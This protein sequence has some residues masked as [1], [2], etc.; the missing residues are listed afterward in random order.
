M[1]ESSAK[2]TREEYEPPALV[3]LG[4]FEEMTKSTSSGKRLDQNFT[5]TAG[6]TLPPVLMS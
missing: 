5:G 6:Q 3:L 2:A 1:N 4:T